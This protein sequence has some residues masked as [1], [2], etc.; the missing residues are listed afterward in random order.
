MKWNAEP[1][2]VGLHGSSQRYG[3][4]CVHAVL[5]LRR[6]FSREELERAVAATV[7]SFH[8]LG[9]LY[10]RRFFRDRWVSMAAP[11][12]A[13]VHVA[14]GDVETETEAWTQRSID[15]TAERSL[16]VVLVPKATGC[17]LVVSM[18]HLAV[19]GAGMAAVGHVLGSHLYGVSPALPVERRRDLGRALDGLTLRHLPVLGRDIVTNLL[20]P[21][22]VYAAAPR[23]RPYPTGGPAVGRTR[24]VILPGSEM[25]A[26]RARCGP[27]VSVNDV[28]LAMVARLGAQRSSKGPVAALYTMDLRRFSRVPHFSAANVSTILTALVPRDATATLAATVK[29]VATITRQHRNSLVG[30]AFVLLPVA[31]MGFAPH[32]VVRRLVPAIHAVAVDPPLR[33]GIIY[34]NVGRIDNGLRPFAGDVEAIRLVGPDVRGVDVPAIIAFG[35][36]GDVHLELFAPP[37]L[38][39]GA[40]VEL[41]AEVRAALQ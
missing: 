4:L 3:D 24:Q 37:G 6:A 31:L 34:T 23:D 2:D 35:F 40:L 17:R 33:R 14:H 32:A 11:T 16:R 27:N 29:E 5:D 30:P 18:S 28:L 9:R 20:Q 38:G 8:V 26:I 22:R 36:R 15:P 13:M 1:I 7:G 41:E 19:D 21:F 39:E 12:S 25:A 10:Q